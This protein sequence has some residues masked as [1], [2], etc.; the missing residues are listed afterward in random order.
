MRL[1]LTALA[2][3]LAGPVAQAQVPRSDA[4]VERL[5]RGSYAHFIPEESAPEPKI[6]L[7]PGLRT[8][9]AQCRAM[10]ARVEKRDGTDA[11]FGACANDYNVL[12]Q[13]QDMNATDWSRIGIAIT[14][15]TPGRLDAAVRFPRAD[16]EAAANEPAIV[17]R[18]VRRGAGWVVSDFNEREMAGDGIEPSYRTRLVQS[19]QQMRAALGLPRWKAPAN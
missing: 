10:Q 11:I 9:E 8:I 12:C 5:I 4:A 16:G 1:G 13:C 17:W 14:H 19:I 15:P 6:P 3:I 7:T 2:L 18:F